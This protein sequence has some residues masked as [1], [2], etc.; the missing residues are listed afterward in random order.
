MRP[1][2]QESEP[3]FREADIRSDTR[4]KTISGKENSG[5]YTGRWPVTI[6]TRR[7][8]ESF[9]KIYVYKATDRRVRRFIYRVYKTKRK[10]RPN[11]RFA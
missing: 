9:V 1:G 2:E 10:L 7:N 3:R 5:P 8:Y 4:S 6:I 11:D